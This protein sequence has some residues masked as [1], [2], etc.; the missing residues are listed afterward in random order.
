MC[1][2]MFGFGEP[3]WSLAAQSRTGR[4][5]ACAALLNVSAEGLVR[6]GVCG[7]ES[8]IVLH[9]VVVTGNIEKISRCK[10]GRVRR[11]SGRVPR[12]WYVRHAKVFE[13]KK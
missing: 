10:G 9:G 4:R 7:V 11:V 3:G 1:V 12:P 2:C 5:V 13:R 6:S 8:G